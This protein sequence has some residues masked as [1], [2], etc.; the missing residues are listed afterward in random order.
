MLC[1]SIDGA[2]QMDFHIVNFRYAAARYGGPHDVSMGVTR[3]LASV[4]SCGY[5][6]NVSM[7]QPVV[8]G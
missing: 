6:A 5:A 3:I 8:L 7:L 4:A 2:F 1:S